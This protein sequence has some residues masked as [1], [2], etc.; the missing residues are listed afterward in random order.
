[1][2]MPFDPAPMLAGLKDFQ[3]QTVE[4]V[5]HRLFVASPSTRRFL[6]ADEVGLGKTLVAKGVIAK[7]IQHLQPTT[8]RI[9]IIY[10]CSN[11]DIASQN[12][13]R[14]NVT[15]QHTFE[16]ATRLTLL[17]Q[18]LHD[19]DP[20][21]QQSRINFVSFTPGTTFDMG[22]RGGTKEERRLMCQMLAAER[23]GRFVAG[24]QRL[25]RAT[26]GEVGWQDYVVQPVD[27]DAKLAHDF[28][29]AVASDEQLA[30]RLS[31][32]AEY[33]YDRRH[34]PDAT[35][36]DRAL[37]LISD[38]R[39]RLAKVCL[40]ALEPDLVILDE[41]QR[42]RDLLNPENPSAELAQTLFKQ[43]GVRVLLLSATPY[44]M[45]ARD[46]EGEDH[47]ADF[48]ETIKF[49]VDGDNTRLD[50][51]KRN[52]DVIRDDL[53]LRVDNRDVSQGLIAKSR[54]QSSLLSVM[55]RTERVGATRGRDAMV[56]KLMT[57]PQ[58]RAADLEDLAFAESVARTVMAP[59]AFDYWKSAPYLFNF[60]GDYKLKR[61]FDD[62]IRNDPA[63]RVALSQ[64]AVSRRPRILAKRTIARFGELDPANG[65]VRVL[66]DEMLNKQLWRLLWLPPS[67][68]YWLPTG[69]FES[70]ADV[71]KTL[72]FSAWNVV[73]DAL[74]AVLS[75]EA[76]RCM[77][78]GRQGIRYNAVE[79]FAGR[80]RGLN[81]FAALCPSPALAELIDPLALARIAMTGGLADSASVLRL[82]K[83]RLSPV[84]EPLLKPA[85]TT[86]SPDARWYWV[87]LAR[88]TMQ[89]Y[90]STKEWDSRAP[91]AD[92]AVSD[93]GMAGS[94]LRF[95]AAFDDMPD[96]PLGRVPDDLHDVIAQLAL[97]SPGVCA[98]RSLR[99][100]APSLKWDDL[101]L[102]AAAWKVAEGFRSLF[103]RPEVVVMLQR[104]ESDSDSYW[105]RILSYALDGN[106]A[107]L[108]DEQVHLLVESL[109]LTDAVEA[110]RVRPIAEEIHT[111]L[112]IHT[113]S[114][115]P[116]DVQLPPEGFNISGQISMRCRYAVR[117]GDQDEQD[118]AV[119]RKE[120][121][122]V[123]FNSPF[124]PFVLATTSVGQEGLDFHQ[125]CH[126][127]VHWNLPS[128]PVD[129]EQREGRVHR[130]KGHAVR[131]NIA[132][133]WRRAVLQDASVDDAWSWMFAAA[134]ADRPPEDTD[135][136]PYWV[137]DVDG[138]AKVER[139]FLVTPLSSEAARCVLL[140][141]GLALYRLVFGQPR[142]ED[143][144]AYLSGVVDDGHM[145]EVIERC[146]IDLE[147]PLLQSDDGPRQEMLNS[148]DNS[149]AL[150][151]NAP[152]GGD[153]A[154]EGGAVAAQERRI[155]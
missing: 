48:L 130:Y 155:E 51:L 85:P 148:M 105:K 47:F 29:G 22:K 62:G 11:A 123:A 23:E 25:S 26:A 78:G 21:P 74:S 96:S 1:M 93:E 24:L 61:C 144:L 36:R 145:R 67:L 115:R 68:P 39:G 34:V 126:S 84:L 37:Q 154:P 149:V 153:C 69:A 54:A 83:E 16:R 52:L 59:G 15:G 117:F 75:Y 125:W 104:E 72:M 106:L 63:K 134:V 132:K 135:L 136:V 107:S 101:G 108:L 3:R 32:L 56:R 88:L 111:A 99:R 116:D 151:G 89:R 82:A 28:R 142:Q 33:F 71:T 90:P 45:Y 137:Y 129:L 95:V 27:F 103:N 76:E 80:L 9:D 73:P 49:L 42:F 4:Y 18:E 65:R 60:M 70:A 17:P 64:L 143:L 10:V 50:A 31:D 5:F 100:V 119:S 102:V 120:A 79:R 40:A 110:E 66:L 131:K 152:E 92:G 128:N 121:I 98:M 77:M 53:L 35:M 94:A 38:L 14:L 12:I 6:V 97:T 127:V 58:M 109:G 43:P 81:T 118:K 87:A 124:R 122:R 86:G 46:D 19:L 8:R 113:A 150:M 7:A 146:R 30:G 147:P 20:D 112:S 2:S 138:G 140:E 13:G 141:R 55:C 133:V 139:R 44:K 41:F 114:L 91:W 57:K